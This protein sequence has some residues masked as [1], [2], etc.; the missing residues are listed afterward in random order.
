MTT[1]GGLCPWQPG[2]PL[3]CSGPCSLPTRLKRRPKQ[4]TAKRLQAG[5]SGRSS[6]PNARMT[7]GYKPFTPCALVFASRSSEASSLSRK[8]RPSLKTHGS[9]CSWTATS[10]SKPSHPSCSPRL[11]STAVAILRSHTVWFMFS[12]SPLLRLRT[13]LGLKPW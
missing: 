2:S 4:T 11:R 12:L 3:S 6:S 1:K 9:H 13:S 5:R 7:R 8:G 10:S